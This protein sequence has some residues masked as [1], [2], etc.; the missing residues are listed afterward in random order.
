MCKMTGYEVKTEF[1]TLFIR[2]ERI[3]TEAIQKVFN[4]LWDKY[5]EN[6]ICLT[7]IVMFMNWN[8]WYWNGAGPSYADDYAKLY[9]ELY[10]KS[11]QYALDTLDGKELQYY[12]RT[13]D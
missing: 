3:G 10:E 11:S 7:E 13:V 9:Q 5:R 4:E 2:A 1:W 12:L 8:L 6:Y